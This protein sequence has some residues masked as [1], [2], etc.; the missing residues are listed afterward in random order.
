[1]RVFTTSAMLHK[2]F[3]A[4]RKNWTLIQS[5]AVFASAWDDIHLGCAIESERTIILRSRALDSL[6]GRQIDPNLCFDDT[7]L[8]MML[9]LM[10]AEF[11]S[12]HETMSQKYEDGIIYN[13]SAR[14]GLHNIDDRTVAE[15]CAA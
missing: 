15:F 1:M 8:T 10:F 6:R 3:P 11:W 14:G 12:C 4:V 2:W 9:H 5:A 13:I 7:T